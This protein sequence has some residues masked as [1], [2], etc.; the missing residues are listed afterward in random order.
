MSEQTPAKPKR[1]WQMGALFHNTARFPHRPERSQT[2]RLA[3]ILRHGLLAPAASADGS[4]CSDL[5]ITVINAAEAYDNLVF[6]HCYGEKSWLYTISMPG[7]FTVFLDPALPVITPEDLAPHW[8]KL[9]QDEVYVRE[10]V[11]LDKFLGIAVHEADADAIL[12]EFQSE[13]ERTGIPLYLHDGETRLW[14]K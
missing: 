3:G 4:V 10:R 11:P 6:L 14:P 5:N 8:A 2:D 13:F 9:S 7:H 12:A 1:L